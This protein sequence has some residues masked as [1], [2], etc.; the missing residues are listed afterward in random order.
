MVRFLLVTPPFVQL[1]TPYPATTCLKAYLQLHQHEVLQCDLGIELTEK[2]FSKTFLRPLFQKA[3]DKERLSPAAQQV[4]MHRDTY[5]NAVESV[6]RFLQGKDNTLAARICSREFLPEGTQFKRIKEE[7]LEWAYGTTGSGDQARFLATLFLEDLT[8]FIAE[9]LECDFSL[10][11]YQEQ[12]ALSAPTFDS[13]YQALQKEPNEIEQLALDLL[14]DKLAAFPADAVGFAI[15]FPG[16]LMMALRLAAHYKKN[17]PSGTVIAGGGYVNTELREISDPRFFEN[18]DF[19]LFDDGELPILSVASHLEGNLPKA[20]LVNARY[21]EQ[22]KVVWSEVRDNALDFDTLPAPDFS[23]LPLDKYISLVEFTNPMHKLWSEGRWNKMTVAHGCYHAKCTFCDTSLDYIARY[24]PAKAATVVDRMES[25]MKQTGISGFHF[26]D[27]ALPPKLLREVAQIILER[28]L[29]VSFWGNIRF[30]K[31]FTP[32]LCRLLAQAGCVA[33]SGGLEVASDGVL[34]RI[35]K[36]VTLEQAVKSCAA[37]NNAGIM[38][39]AYLMYGFPGQNREEALE[40]LEIVRQMFEEGIIQSG[41]WHRY[42]M[43]VHSPTGC[44]PEKF[45]AQRVSGEP[46]P[47]ANNGVEF[48]DGSQVDWD[49]IG[50]ALKTATQ[51]FMQ[52]RG[53]ELP[54]SKWFGKGYQNPPLSKRFVAK[55]AQR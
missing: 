52:G 8:A 39:H 38:V 54:I 6:L 36:G 17:H 24:S 26:T 1:N 28:G 12:I 22:G 35:C 15:P 14:T 31:S 25:I 55:L 11:R 21:V 4:A 5:I 42:T 13:I 46:F 53:Y 41:F 49:T 18:I 16:T 45:G 29:C 40:S 23:D 51:N 48:T 19:L 34:K 33:V 2:I 44:N 27:E 37:F 9:I 10:I 50:Y 7:D 47:F 3:F 30:E 43:T 20:H 32:E